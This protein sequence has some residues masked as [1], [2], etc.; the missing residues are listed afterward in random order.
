MR[1]SFGAADVA[2]ILGVDEASVVAIAEA[3]ILGS[4]GLQGSN[5]VDFSSSQV[6]GFVDRLRRAA[7]PTS[8]SV[9]GLRLVDAVKAAGLAS[10]DWPAVLSSFLKGRINVYRRAGAYGEPLFDSFLVSSERVLELVVVDTPFIWLP[11]C[12]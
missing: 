8:T 6:D 10:K 3:G 12:A 5:R 11:R 4:G 1:V 9:D 7:L 2:K